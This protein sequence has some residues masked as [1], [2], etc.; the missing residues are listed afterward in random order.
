MSTSALR[1][2]PQPHAGDPTVPCSGADVA[3]LRTL[4]TLQALS[5]QRQEYDAQDAHP[6]DCLDALRAALPDCDVLA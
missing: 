2:R 3:V 5:L 1:P 6:R 4:S